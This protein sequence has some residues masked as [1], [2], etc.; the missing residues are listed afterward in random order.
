MCKDIGTVADLTAAA[1]ACA[2]VGSCFSVEG[3]SWMI[4][5]ERFDSAARTIAVSCS[6][7]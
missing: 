4:S 7:L 1:A 5:G 6:I 3:K 2:R